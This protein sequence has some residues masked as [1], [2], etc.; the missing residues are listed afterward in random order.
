[1]A[2]RKRAG[3]RIIADALIER[4]GF[5]VR[6]ELRLRVVEFIAIRLQGS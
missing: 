6:T 5:S 3:W 4:V 1:M 2:R